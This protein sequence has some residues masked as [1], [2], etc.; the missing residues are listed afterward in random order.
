MT[1][2]IVKTQCQIM[3]II[4]PPRCKSS[5][6][7]PRFVWALTSGT[8]SL[9]RWRSTLLDTSK[10]TLCGRTKA[11]RDKIS[12]WGLF[13]KY[14]TRHATQAR[15]TSLTYTATIRSTQN[16]NLILSS[17]SSAG[18]LSS[19]PCGQTWATRGSTS[20]AWS[21]VLA[22]TQK[23]VRVFWSMP[24]KSGSCPRKS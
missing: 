20:C 11:T 23:T 15:A 9:I 3:P 22:V 14:L 21:A 18:A 16:T 19:A 17:R 12:N 4:V 8:N 2:R 10:C 24:S 1:T 6:N 7:D 5:K 13:N